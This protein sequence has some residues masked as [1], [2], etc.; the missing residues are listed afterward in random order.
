M[1]TLQIMQNNP[2]LVMMGEEFYPRDELL[3]LVWKAA[4]E[5]DMFISEAVNGNDGIDNL[6]KNIA[7]P[8]NDMI[9]DTAQELAGQLRRLYR[10]YAA[11][12]VS[13]EQE[14]FCSWWLE[15]EHAA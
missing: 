6:M 2:E 9:F 13:E 14:N 4:S 7:D 8:D 10:R 11:F 3:D 1:N 12:L 15:R 5:D